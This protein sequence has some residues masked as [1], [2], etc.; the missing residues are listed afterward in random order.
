VHTTTDSI[1]P[2]KS[3]VPHHRMLGRGTLPQSLCFVE[4][5]TTDGRK[6]GYTPAVKQRRED[7]ILCAPTIAFLLFSVSWCLVVWLQD[8][9]QEILHQIQHTRH[10]LS[11]HISSALSSNNPSKRATQFENPIDVISVKCFQAHQ[12]SSAVLFREQRAATCTGL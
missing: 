12:R 7:A 8:D 4:R 5:A 10:M 2:L 1:E 6:L 11:H 3:S 9:F